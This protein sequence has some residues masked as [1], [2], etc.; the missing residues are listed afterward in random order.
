[1]RTPI[2]TLV[3]VHTSACVGT[4]P[5][6]VRHI[7]LHAVVIKVVVFFRILFRFV[8]GRS[9]GRVASTQLGPASALAVRL[10]L[11]C[12]PWS[13]PSVRRYFGIFLILILVSSYFQSQ[14]SF[15]HTV[16]FSSH[17]MTNKTTSTSF[18]ALSMI[19]LQLPSSLGVF[20]FLSYPA[21]LLHAS[22]STFSFPPHSTSS[23]AL[24]SPPMSQSR[25]PVLI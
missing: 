1:M 2:Q 9:V 8:W 10:Y 4:Y 25:A 18:P 6:S 15:P 13:R 7:S 17:C 22:T 21:S 12:P 23:H 5:K 20:H 16:L 19:F 3:C 11:P 14:H 24:S